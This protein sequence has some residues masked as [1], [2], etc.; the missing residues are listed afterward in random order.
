MNKSTIAGMIQAD[1]TILDD[2]PGFITRMNLKNIRQVRNIQTVISQEEYYISIADNN[3]GECTQA[4]IDGALI[5]N[6]S[7]PLL[8]EAE[9]RYNNAISAIQSG[10]VT[11]RDEL[12]QVLSA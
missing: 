8:D 9:M 2:I 10:E 6:E 11:T 4:D 1:P 5:L 12:K 7:K 3:G